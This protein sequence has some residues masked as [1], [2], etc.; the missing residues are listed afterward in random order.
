MTRK[1]A[2]RLGGLAR[3][4]PSRPPAARRSPPSASPPWSRNASAAT[5]APPSSGWSPPASRRRTASSARRSGRSAAR[6]RSS[7]W[8][9]T[10]DPCRPRPRP[11][12]S[13]RSRPA[14]SRANHPQQE[15][16][17]AMRKTA[18]SATTATPA[19]TTTTT[20]AA[21]RRGRRPRPLG[22]TR[23]GLRRRGS[24]LPPRPPRRPALHHRPRGKA[25][26]QRR[27]RTGQL[28]LPHR[29]G[30]P[31]GPLQLDDPFARRPRRHAG[32][33]R[34]LPRHARRGRPRQGR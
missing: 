5:A 33:H 31:L 9:T 28:V 16:H 25:E 32:G 22:T 17:N 19:T 1:D 34:W 12:T 26:A 2:A 18:T 14:N 27:P 13:T 15:P 24:P 6:A 29:A 4:A 10:Q 20:S 8:P 23:R 7:P 11:R 3:A 21:S 30:R